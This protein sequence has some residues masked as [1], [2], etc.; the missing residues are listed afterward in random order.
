M[1]F[2]AVN[3]AL[4]NGEVLQ[5]DTVNIGVAVALDNGLMVPVIR[6]A[7]TKSLAE[8]RA[9]IAALSEVART[10]T[11][12]PDALSGGTFTVTNL[13]MFGVDHFNPVLNPPEA[14][15]LGVCRV[16]EK[17]AI[18]DG[19]IVIRP[20]MNICLAFDHRVVDGAT[21]ARFLER[22]RNFL[23]TPLLML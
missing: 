12:S 14:G 15:I 2:P 8:L 17:P 18:V 11:V 1:E 5:F 9:E 20:F 4:V 22:I 19:A 16:I 23:E 6:D 10:G 13:G 7:Q 3:S 21:G